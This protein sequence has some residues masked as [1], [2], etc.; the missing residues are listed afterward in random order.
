MSTGI[1]EYNTRI[2]IDEMNDMV[3][4]LSDYI[5]A[6]DKDRLMKNIRHWN[7]Y[8]GYHWEDIQAYDK[9]QTTKNYCRPFVDKFVAFEFGKGFSIR[10]PYEDKV[11]ND[12]PQERVITTFL[13][14]IWN[15]H[16][17][18]DKL[19]LEVGQTKAITGKCW[20]QVKYESTQDLYDPFGEYPNGRIRIIPMS[21]NT[22]FPEYDPHD[23]DKLVKLTVMY[24]YKE[25]ELS[26]IIKTPKIKTKVYRAVWTNDEVTVYEGDKDPVT[27]ENL[28]KVI[29]FVEIINYPLA[30]RTEGASDLDDIIPLNVELN[31]KNSDIS[32]I[33]DYHA[34]PVTLVYGANASSLE[35]GANKMWGGL[36]K[37]ARVENLNMNTDLGA[38]LGYVND[39]KLAIHEIGSVPINALGNTQAISNTSGVALQII[40]MPLIERTRVKRISTTSGIQQINKLIL[41]IGIQQNIIEVPSDVSAKEFY[42]TQIK[43][44]DALPKDTL[45]E[46]QQIESEMRLGLESRNEAMIRLGKDPKKVLDSMKDDFEANPE[47]YGH[48]PKQINSGM[49]NGETKE[50]VVNKELRGE[51]VGFNR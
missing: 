33:I 35:R 12:T 44:Q 16:N 51:N 50:E 10:V 28:Y 5:T 29:P 30:N 1:Y 24:P 23:K 7:F 8:E 27:T 19:M 48:Q 2:R 42:Q 49:M 26:P 32:E 17:N 11:E 40:H 38:S 20:V 6:T 3:M 13:E 45:I 41:L 43:F 46:L 31:L 15:E 22:I 34:S 9:P 4:A 14:E 39:T 36:P 37:D 18:R 21:S 47:F 25:P